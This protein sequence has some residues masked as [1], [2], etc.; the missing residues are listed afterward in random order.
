MIK[1]I[2]SVDAYINT[3]SAETQEQLNCI[4][5]IILDNAPDAIES[6]SYGMP[7]YKTHQN[8]LVYFAGYANHIGFY[9]TP[10]G[11]EAFAEELKH[12]KQGKGSIQFPLN[13]PLPIDLITRIVKFRVEENNNNK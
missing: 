6:L 4:R 10:T 11:H 7:A 9:A 13:A 8:P 3:F 2:N 1:N 12:F 5:K